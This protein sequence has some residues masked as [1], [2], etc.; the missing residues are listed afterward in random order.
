MRAALIVIVL[1]YL[2]LGAWY[3][4]AIPFG[5]APDE[6]AHLVY[7]QYLAKEHRLPVFRP[8]GAG[9]YEFHQPPLYYAL[10]LPAYLAGGRRAV[11]L[12]NVVLGL[13]VILFTYLLCREIFPDRPWRAVAA[14]AF[15]A[16]L[17]MH[18]ALCASVTNDV[19]A[20]V[21]FTA[22]LWQM[23]R[24]LRVGWSPRA[25][26]AVG[27]LA[28]LG[29]LTKS[30]TA[31]LLVV[32]WLAVARS[33]R[34]GWRV[35][36]RDIGLM[37]AAA[38]VIGGWWL[39]RNQVLYGDPLAGRAFLEAFRDRPT[40]A[41][42]MA[43][44]GLS[45]ALY[46]LWVKGWTFA[47]FWGVFGT[48]NV[49]LPTGVYVALGAFSAAALVGVIARLARWRQLEAWQRQALLTLGFAALL[50]GLLFV[51]FNM[52]YF[53]AQARYLFPVIGVL[54]IG[55]VSGISALVPRPAR[56]AV[57]FLPGVVALVVALAALPTWI[58]PQMRMR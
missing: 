41:G 54:A 20:E 34:A 19:L 39:V 1:I 50:V 58:L 40:P 46:L 55:I 3:A 31:P 33:R 14:A 16:F 38:V 42:Q 23:V 29:L 49:F 43:K 56:T 24:G 12:F 7:V 47:S 57:A 5:Q 25:C 44:Y 18:L 36:A 28:G 35:A 6:S 45:L 32:G 52:S 10:S 27:A 9:G 48:M 51:R 13:G 21:I 4:A 11:R 26:A 22:G 15:A 30:A 2:A 37:T 53:Q 8:V 17:P